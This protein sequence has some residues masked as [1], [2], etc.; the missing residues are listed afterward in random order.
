MTGGV[1]S[2]IFKDGTVCP[3][4]L[5]A[6]LLTAGHVALPPTGHVVVPLTS[7]VGDTRRSVD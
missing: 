3:S 6:E 5:D 2:V 4:L 1:D 7:L